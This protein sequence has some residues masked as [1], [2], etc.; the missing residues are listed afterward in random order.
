M[1]EKIKPDKW[2]VFPA[3]CSN[4]LTRLPVTVF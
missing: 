1:T 4:I 3:I 2:L